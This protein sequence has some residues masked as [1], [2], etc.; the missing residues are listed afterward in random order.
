MQ[1]VAAASVHNL[2][3]STHALCHK[4]TAALPVILGNVLPEDP[5][6]RVKFGFEAEENHALGCR[7]KIKA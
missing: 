2:V 1:G 6:I 7:A 4:P 3:A 5:E